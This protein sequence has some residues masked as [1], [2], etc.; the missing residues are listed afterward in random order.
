[1]SGI[2]PAET[3]IDAALVRGLINDQHP[4]LCELPLTAVD[5]GWDN[6]IFRL[7][8]HLAARLPRRVLGA[9]CIEHEQAWLPLLASRLPIPAPASVRVGAPGRGYPWRW[10][11]V[12]W[13]DGET[14]HE[15]PPGAAEAGR[16]A[17]FLIAL[18]AP[19]GPEAPLNPYRGIALSGRAAD[20]EARLDRLSAAGR[21]VDPLVLAAWREGLSA[22]EARERRWLH[23]DLH[24][25]NVLVRG[26]A[27]AAVLDWGDITAGD[28]ATDLASVWHLFDS[29]L[30][31]EQVLSA[32]GA[33]A[34]LRARA[35]GW[36]ACI[37]VVLAGVD[38]RT[39]RAMGAAVLRR[40]A[41][42]G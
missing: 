38:D 1:M 29:A 25:R 41:E 27:F 15:S 26:G 24:A 16:W 3:P 36:A 6:Q 21:P 30:A 23:G 2:P 28:V 37:G 11:I 35:R 4:D 42:E 13:F 19:A 33:D 9:T 32:Y 18:H 7:G 20:F 34:A 8:D 40:I 5:G 14:A 10:S 22:P 17:A 12:P 39:H 31:R